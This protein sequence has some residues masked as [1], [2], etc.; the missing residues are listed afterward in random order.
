[1]ARNLDEKQWKVLLQRIKSQNCVPF[2]GGAMH[3]PGR[4]KPGCELAREWATAYRYPL[5]D[6]ND[7]ARVARFVATEYDGFFLR[8]QIADQIR[9]A[10]PPDFQDPLEP[11]R[12]LA[13]LNLKM[14]MTTNYD[15]FMFQ[16]LKARHKEPQWECC[17][18][19]AGLRNEPSVFDAADVRI[20]AANPLVYHFHGHVNEL[21]S[22][23]VT[24]DDYLDFLANLA[25]DKKLIPPLIQRTLAQSSL[26]FMGYR[27]Y[28]WD[29]RVLFRS[30]ASFIKR[31][32]LEKRVNVAVQLVPLNDDAEQDQITEAMNFLDK[33]F[34]NYDVRV[35]WGDCHQFVAELRR[36]WDEYNARGAA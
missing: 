27:V 3:R 15:D 4:I 17:R 26:L 12:V 6:K 1:M 23:V 2:L 18:W 32:E 11:H 34:E 13:D 36:R 8:D 24:E 22:M 7:L 31:S 10:I 28:D 25:E 30:L 33:Y 21:N 19:H 35:F 5:D 20:N 29:F 16:A 9:T 14:Y